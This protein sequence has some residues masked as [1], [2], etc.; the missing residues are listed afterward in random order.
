MNVLLADTI[1]TMNPAREIVRGG[2]IVFDENV[3]EV[4]DDLEA[5]EKRKKTARVIDCGRG[6]IAMPGL[7]NAHTH[8][9]FSGT[10]TELNYGSFIAWLSSVIEKRETLVKGLSKELIDGVLDETLRGGTTTI[11]AISS[12]GFDLDSLAD[13][14]QKTICFNELIGSNPAASEQIFSAFLNRVAKSDEYRS[15]RFVSAIAIH[16]PYS[17]SPA[18][19]KKAIALSQSR[20]TPLSVHFLESKSERKW[21]ESSSGEFKPFFEKVFKLDSPFCNAQEFLSFFGDGGKILFTHCVAA[22]DEELDAIG[23]IGGAIVHCPVSN[24]LLGCGL[25]SLEKLKNREISYLVATDGLSSNYSLNLFGELRSALFMHE[26]LDLPLLAR[27]LLRSVT[28]SAAR[29]LGLNTGRLASGYA[30]DII[31]FRLPGEVSD[32]SLLPLQA[33]LRAPSAMDYIFINGESAL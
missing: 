28:D 27:D 1:L 33:I 3:I 13:A 9:E 31:C 18:L 14:K 19:V 24:R 4:T 26:G 21:L 8:L 17:V 11:G 16:S 20:K 30:A 25:L 22:N 32:D 15:D 7:I 2:A 6:S 29:A 23:K 5:I 10:S 12:Y